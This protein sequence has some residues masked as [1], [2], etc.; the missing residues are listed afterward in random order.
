MIFRKEPPRNITLPSAA[1]HSAS[2][3]LSAATVCQQNW[4]HRGTVQRECKEIHPWICG[5]YWQDVNSISTVILRCYPKAFPR[6]EKVVSLTISFGYQQWLGCHAAW[7][8]ANPKENKHSV[9]LLVN[10]ATFIRCHMLVWGLSLFWLG[11]AL[12]VA[13]SCG[14]SEVQNIQSCSLTLRIHASCAFR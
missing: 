2:V 10:I 6:W 13:L 14:N 11:A 5:R 7:E 4:S 8:A 3:G 9:M 12:S 1:A